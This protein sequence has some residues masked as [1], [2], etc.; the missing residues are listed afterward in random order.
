MESEHPTKLD[1]LM[2]AVAEHRPIRA[3]VELS[4]E[5]FGARIESNSVALVEALRAGLREHVAAQIDLPLVAI[6]ASEPD[7]GFTFRD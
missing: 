2:H 5:G 1:R 7:L 3:A 4:I 6:E